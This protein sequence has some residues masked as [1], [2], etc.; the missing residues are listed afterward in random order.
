MTLKPATKSTALM[1]ALAALTLGTT[2]VR[3]E[4]SFSGLFNIGAQ[5][6]LVPG[7]PKWIKIGSRTVEAD[8]LKADFDTANLPGR[9]VAFHLVAE[10]GTIEIARVTAKFD[11][12]KSLIDNRFT[13]L[14]PDSKGHN[15]TF[16]GGERSVENVAVVSSI[17]RRHSRNALI[18]LYGL[19]V[20]DIPTPPL[21]EKIS[22]QTIQSAAETSER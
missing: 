7:K 1:I 13:I 10:H 18:A 9:F 21:P 3:S 16:R 22:R 5:K 8:V 6:Q 15:I 12:G 4:K 11:S 20:V 17:P 2:N 19:Q 14:K